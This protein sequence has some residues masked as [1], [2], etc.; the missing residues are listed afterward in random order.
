M[1]E[2][3]LENGFKIDLETSEKVF[4]PTGTTETVIEAVLENN[5]EKKI[6]TKKCKCVNC[7]CQKCNAD[8]T[9]WDGVWECDVDCN[10]GSEMGDCCSEK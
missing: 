4:T 2:F 8:E 9:P 6:M 10:H 5:K 1:I 3:K 7:E